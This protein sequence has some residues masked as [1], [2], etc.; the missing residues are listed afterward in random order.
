MD[1]R[2]RT[3]AHRRAVLVMAT[4]LGPYA[5]ERWQWQDASAGGIG[6]LEAAARV[7]GVALWLEAERSGV[8][9]GEVDLEAVAR[10]LGDSGAARAWLEEGLADRSVATRVGQEEGPAGRSP[11]EAASA[12]ELLNLLGMS[13]TEWK[14]THRLVLSRLCDLTS[15]D[16]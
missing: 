10:R 14:I 8:A 6:G 13:P 9:A 16:S 12:G 4:G 1:S 7:L 11:M 3:D 2:T 15:L 5:P